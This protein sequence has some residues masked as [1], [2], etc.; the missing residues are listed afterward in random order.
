MAAMAS[1][2][3]VINATDE[4]KAAYNLT[5]EAVGHLISLMKVGTPLK[6]VYNGTK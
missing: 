3:V 2:T 4:Q 6:D 5:L 1:R